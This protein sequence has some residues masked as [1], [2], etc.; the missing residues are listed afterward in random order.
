MSIQ[1][2]PIKT[3]STENSVE[4]LLRDSKKQLEEYNE[5]VKK[6]FKSIDSLNENIKILDKENQKRSKEISALNKFGTGALK[7]TEDESDDKGKIQNK[8]QLDSS[9]PKPSA[10]KETRSC[11]SSPDRESKSSFSNNQLSPATKIIRTM[12]VLKGKDDLGIEDFITSVKRARDRCSDPDLLL[13]LIIAEKIQEN[14][15]RAIRYLDIT[16]YDILFSELRK[17]LSNITSVSVCRKKLRGTRQNNDCVQTFNIKFRQGSN[18]LKYAIQS[19]QS[20][21]LERRILLKDADKSAISA[22]IENLKYKIAVQVKAK[23]Q[24]HL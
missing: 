10:P 19:E 17:N 7:I 20:N 21:P 24:V 18:E 8:F 3:G 5:L 6:L 15:E 2:T 23:I 22:Y 12:K 13:D 11:T 16:S 1:N 9:K 4:D 14:A